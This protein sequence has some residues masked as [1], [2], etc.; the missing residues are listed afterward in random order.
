[1]PTPYETG[2]YGSG[3]GGVGTLSDAIGRLRNSLNGTSAANAFTARESALAREFNSAEAAKN[4]AWEEMMSN[5]AYQRQVEDLKAAGLNPV[6]ALGSGSGAST[7]SG[8]SATANSAMSVG[9]G[10]SGSILGVIGN[11][12]KTALSIAL[13]KKFG[14]SAQSATTA[15][16]SVAATTKELKAAQAE[17]ARTNAYNQIAR[18][19]AAQWK[20]YGIDVGQ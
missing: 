9:T 12:A 19:K 14:H 20:K 15:A 4:R 18:Q 2:G 7:P 6:M 10:H 17:L 13:F 1:M 16:G 3:S 11:I 5:T 8:Y